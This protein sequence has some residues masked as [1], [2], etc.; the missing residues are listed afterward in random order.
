MVVFTAEP[1]SPSGRA[2]QLLSVLGT[3]NMDIQA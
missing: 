3:Q 2:L 1:G